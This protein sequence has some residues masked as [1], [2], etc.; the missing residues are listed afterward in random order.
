MNFIKAIQAL[1]ESDS[2]IVSLDLRTSL[3]SPSVPLSSATAF[4]FVFGGEP[5]AAG[6]FISESNALTISTVYA[7]VRLIAESIGTFPVKVYDTSGNG[8]NVAQNHSFSHLLSSEPN[9]EMSA[10]T[11]FES[12]AGSLA[13]TGNCYAEIE[14]NKKGATVALWPLNPLVTSPIRDANGKIVFKTSDGG[15]ERILAA[16][17]VIHVPLFS[18]DGLKGLSP[19]QQARQALGLAQATVKQGARFFSNGSRPG[20]I[21]TPNQPVT[22]EIGQQMKAAWESMASG[23][24]QGRI[25]VLPSD[26]SYTQL[27]LSLE[28]SQFLA[29]RAFSRNEI[30]ALFRIDPHYLGDTT[31]QSNANHEQTSLS[32]LQETLQPYITKIEQELNRKLLPPTGGFSS[33]YRIAFDYTERLKTD[34]KTTLDSIAVGRQWGILTANEGR[35]RIGL[36]PVGADGDILYSP[37]N[38]MDS[39]RFPEWFPTK[40]EPSPADPPARSKRKKINAES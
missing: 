11:F 40:S 15:T 26:W 23:I 33:V 10:S 32:L 28:D 36:N 22:P 13:L 27:G 1:R 8:K 17:D 35:E 38:M 39:A 14:R 3:E 19:I 16:K 21:L 29:S 12:L 31:R 6:E 30:G 37:I 5:T 34:L 2:G 25:A 7:C 18:F 24:N 4:N 20:G 9:P